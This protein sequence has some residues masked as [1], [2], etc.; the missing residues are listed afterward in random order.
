MKKGIVSLMMMLPVSALANQTLITEIE[1]ENLWLGANYVSSSVD[2]TLSAQGNSTSTNIDA[3]VKSISITKAINATHSVTPIL[4]LSFAKSH[5]DGDS[6]NFYNAGVG[7]KIN[8]NEASD[9]VIMAGYNG[10]SD[11]DVRSAVDA[12]IAF[13]TRTQSFYNEMAISAILPENTSDVEG[14]GSFSLVNS[15]KISPANNLSLTGLIGVALE[16][17]TDIGDDYTISSGPAFI[18]GGE[19]EVFFNKNISAAVSLVKS[20][21]N[22][23]A[24]ISDLNIDMDMDVTTVQASL[25]ARF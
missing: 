12:F 9:L 3:D 23:D 10:S 21:A 1:A 24:V 4:S 11:D 8:V 18:F 7:T 5:S 16:T 13:G 22:S 15:I 14:G 19:V 25:N 17:D 6:S 2:L 20:S